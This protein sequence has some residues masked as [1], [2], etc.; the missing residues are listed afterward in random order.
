MAQTVTDCEQRVAGLKEELETKIADLNSQYATL[1]QTVSGN[2]NAIADLNAE[3][4]VIK[5]KLAA[6]EALDPAQGFKDATALLKSDDDT[7]SL[8][9]FQDLWDAYEANKNYYAAFDVFD[10]ELARIEF[11]LLR[12]FS[13]EDI[14][15]LIDDD[16][17]AAIEA[18]ED[19][20][21]RD[22]FPAWLESFKGKVTFDTDLSQV[23]AVFAILPEDTQLA[24]EAEYK[25]LLK[26]KEVLSAAKAELDALNA[27]IAAV[28]T[29]VYNDNVAEV[30]AC[31]AAY[32]Q[33][34][35]AYF[36]PDGE[37]M[38]YAYYKTGD[39]INEMLGNYDVLVA[40]EARVAELNKALSAIV[41]IIDEIKNYQTARPLFSDLDAI[42]ANKAAVAAWIDEYKLEAANVTA[43]YTADG[44]L[45][46][47]QL[48]DAA[49]AYAK[50]MSALHEQYVLAEAYSG[51]T[52]AAIIADMKAKL[53]AN[54]LTLSAD[55]ANVKA[56]KDAM[57]ALATAVTTVADYDGT[58]DGNYAAMTDGFYA[59]YAAVADRID[60]L[61]AF[62]LDL[63]KLKAKMDLIKKVDFADY[64]AINQFRIDLDG[65][66]TTYS[67]TVG[68]A[69]YTELA[70][71]TEARYLELRT[72]YEDITKE[73]AD[74]YT[75]AMNILAIFRDEDGN[76]VPT[77]E[78]GNKLIEVYG[79]LSTIVL[80][81]GLTEVVL[82]L[83]TGD[84]NA[85]IEILYNDFIDILVL[86]GAKAMDAQSDAAAWKET[87]G[88]L[89]K[90]AADLNNYTA[91]STVYGEL[92]AWYKLYV[93]AELDVTADGVIALMRTELEKL[94]AI[95][96]FDGDE[97]VD[98]YVF[99]SLSDFDVITELYVEAASAY[100][101]AA[102]EAAAL[103]AAMAA[104]IKDW[105]VHSD[106]V[107]VQAKYD[108]F[109]ADFFGGAIVND[110]VAGNHDLFN[111]LPV[112]GDATTPDTF[113]YVKILYDAACLV[114]QYMA[115]EINGLIAALPSGP[116]NM[117]D[118]EAVLE[119]IQI[120]R[121]KMA[122]FYLNGSHCADGCEEC[123]DKFFTVAGVDNVFKL[124]RVTKRAEMAKAYND[125]YLVA[126][127]DMQADL[128]EMKKLA[129]RMITDASN[130]DG[131]I[132]GYT[133][134]MERLNEMTK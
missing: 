17:G 77:L 26:A 76:M 20:D 103:K 64:A 91:I 133:F 81:K 82:P 18:L 94:Q 78:Y 50:A 115:D 52:M 110:P 6:L 15:A 96:I 27:S 28:G 24:N 80:G 89:A 1:S 60:E 59:D 134:G 124:Y 42:K 12:A 117:A 3:M 30:E 79:K 13:V 122:D 65:L 21:Y 71:K 25:A 58:I 43:L 36:A 108:S 54:T 51:K 9:A 68:D 70:E 4:A 86:Y 104:L 61:N 11:Y 126:D 47:Y 49:L 113:T 31:R 38:A 97:I 46:G 102:E 5:V 130:E 75:E 41:A 90:N 116:V 22:N 118:G 32:E 88:K 10:A 83:P 23:Q 57:S 29:V 109:V 99:V 8:K 37:P 73:I 112:Y 72:A 19:S 106:F 74:L 2:A 16:L 92:V 93:N 69:N 35:S 98:L 129:D 39:L 84:A 55:E 48:I 127:A 107:T 87:L 120:I 123:V 132:T 101:E 125:A 100:A 33:I 119:Q 56:I 114:A 7:Y 105:N 14:K 34:K 128:V 95:E 62:K 131:I 45:A 111:I 40:L 44:T 121:S 63:A 67:I 53:D 85:N 66:Y